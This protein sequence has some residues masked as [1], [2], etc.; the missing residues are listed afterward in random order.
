MTRNR[1]IAVISAIVGAA[2]F[3]CFETPGGRHCYVNWRILQ[4]SPNIRPRMALQPGKVTYPA[5]PAV[6]PVNLGF[7]SADTGTSSVSTVSAFKI[8]NGIGLKYADVMV[9]LFSPHNP[10]APA[11][12]KSQVAMLAESHASTDPRFAEWARG[13]ETNPVAAEVDAEKAQLLPYSTIFFMSED[14]FLVYNN[15][16]M[17]KGVRWPD[18]YAVNI[19]ETPNV[20]GIVWIRKTTTG[21]QSADADLTSPDGTKVVSLNA[22][23]PGNSPRTISQVLDPILGSFRFT[24]DSV[25]DPAHVQALIHEAGIPPSAPQ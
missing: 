15:R 12:E 14:D 10:Q 19:F 9:I 6:H 20:K 3:L 22:Y 18:A 23:I 5:M 21:G 2:L 24:A 1:I 16:L 13:W 25:T 7:A 8:G 11:A 17:M 4:L